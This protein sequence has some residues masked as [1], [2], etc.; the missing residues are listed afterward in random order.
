VRLDLTTG[1]DRFASTTTVTFN[2]AQPGAS[3]FIEFIGPSVQSAVLNGRAVAASAFADGR[4][5]LEGL[6][7]Q[8]RLEVDA[9][10]RYMHDGTGMHRFVDPVDGRHYLHT[11]FESNDAHRV[12]AC[13]DQPDLKATFNFTV[14]APEDWVVVSNS[15]PTSREGGLWV[16]PTTRRISTYITA[17]VA[18]QYAEW[19]EQYGDIPLGLFCRQSLAQYFDPDEVFEITRQGLDFFARR[20]GYP[21]PFGKYDQLFVPEFSAGAMENAACV[22]HS[23]R[24]VYRSRVTEATRLQRAETI[25]HEMAHMWF[26]DLVT[27]RWFND[28]WLNESFATYMAYVAMFEA[29]R[30]KSAWLDFAYKM[31]TRAKVQ[32]QLPSTHPIVADMPDVDA[33]HLNFDSITYEKGAAT[34]KQLVAWVGEESFFEGLNRYFHRHEYRNT[35]LPDFLA[36]LEEASGRDLHWWSSV[37][38]ET[39]GVNTIGAELE[40]ENGR[41][42]RAS[43]HQTAPPSH[44]TLRPHRLRV[45]LFD[46]S[47]DALK[48]RKSVELDV[49]AAPE[50]AL[51]QLTGEPAPDLLLVNDGD[52]A[53]TKLHFDSRSIKTL[54]THLAGIEDALARAVAWGALWDMV[55]DAQLRARDYVPIVLSNVDVEPD[56]VMVTQLIAMMN[57]AIEAYS[58]PGNRA[59]LREQLAAGAKARSQAAEPG[60][61]RQLIWTR[62]L[63]D[64]ARSPEDVDWVRGLLDGSA[65]PPGLKVDYAVRWLA[66]QA[67]ARIG[68]IGGEEIASELDRD[69]TEEGRRAAATARAARPLPEAKEEA[70]SAVIDGDE[71]SLAMKRA[72]VA[73]FH[74][75]DQEALL[76]PY[77]RRYFD[78][79]LPVWE[80]HEIDEGLEFV[81]GMFPEKIVRADVI[82]LAEETL[83]GELPGPVHR[84]LLEAQDINARLL[85]ARGFDATAGAPAGS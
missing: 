21:Y 39:A 41:V 58:E 2:C 9:T 70:W 19:H 31:K 12:Y 36:P 5:Q 3:T 20:F 22:T 62:A 48:R 78:D 69:P 66:V 44:P 76:E 57:A 8:N 81:E 17:V 50:T 71:V 72:F 14:R 85:R 33:V 45:G 49:A 74:R 83:A 34:L 60:S 82:E 51:D 64:A 61:D 1:A 11:Q 15:T 6:L 84:A 65:A 30:F 27:M 29:T 42:K 32:D 73:G 80:A 47:G 23:E 55:R 46:A 35:E 67:L 24:M 7:A 13:F 25:L 16:F 63:I 52:L 43:L 28:L 75:A 59:A 53:Y 26:G 37:W 54:A 77:V 18:G 10:A 79:L 68:A 4:L 40:V 56:A 38:L